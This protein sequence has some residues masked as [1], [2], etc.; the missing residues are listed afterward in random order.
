MYYGI[1]NYINIV[2]G[3]ETDIV[4]DENYDKHNLNNIIEWWKK[5]A[6][7]RYNNLKNENRLRKELEIW[8]PDAQIQIIR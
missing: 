3:T 5:K 4:K 6:T 1:K 2:N 8:S 7:N